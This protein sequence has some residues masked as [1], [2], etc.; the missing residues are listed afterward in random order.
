MHELSSVDD[1]HSERIKQMFE[2]IGDG[3]FPFANM[4]FLLFEDVIQWF[5]CEDVRGMNY[6][7]VVKLFWATGRS[8]FQNK[9][10]EFMR[11]PFFKG[12]ERDGQQLNP[13]KLPSNFNRR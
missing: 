9:F 13:V 2:L 1:V 11:G 7:E 10:L 6:S 8:L 4:C 5:K 3:V 12:T